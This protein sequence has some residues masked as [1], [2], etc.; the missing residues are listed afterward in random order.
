MTLGKKPFE[1]IVGKGKKSWFSILSK[2]PKFIL[3]TFNLMHAKHLIW[4]GPKC[5]ATMPTHYQ[6]RKFWIFPNSKHLQMKKIQTNN[7]IHL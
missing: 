4:F 1:N 3:S 5:H 7:I 2:I 6:T